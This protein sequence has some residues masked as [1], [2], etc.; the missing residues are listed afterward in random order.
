[1]GKKFYPAIFIL[2]VF[3][4]SVYSRGK[5]DIEEKNV[6]NLDG[7]QES[8]DLTGKSPGKYNIMITATDLGGNQT[9][10][11]PYNIYID[12]KSDLP[13]CGITNP[14]ER[15]R[16]VSNLNIV[17]TCVDDDGVAFVNLILDGDESHP[18]RAEGKEFWSYYLDTRNLAEGPH[19]IK[20]T[21]TDINGLEGKSVSLTWNLDRRQ[22]VTTV[23]NCGM[24]TLVSGS[25]K[26]RGT[27]SDGNG[28]QSLSYS[29]DTGKH[30]TG[31]KITENKKDRN[32]TFDIPVD[33]K[34]TPDGPSVIW[35]KATD[36]AGSVGIYSFLYF[37]D[38]TSP[39]VKI[40]LPEEK[41]PQNGKFYA[42]GY[43]KDKL[44]ITKLT[45]T[46][47][48]DSGEFKLIPGNPYWSHE[49]DTTGLKD[50]S[51]KF[52]VAA[53]DR[54]GN[55]TTVSRTI[56]L[57]QE[58]DK[59]VVTISEPAAGELVDTGK[60]L[61]VRGSAADD[62][63]VQSVTYSIDGVDAGSQ[64]TK[65]V[66]YAPVDGS[67]LKAGKHTVAVTA[68]DRNGVA[69]NPAV[70]SFTAEGPALSFTD[71]VI[72][73]GKDSVPAVNGLDVNPESSSLY[74]TTVS[75]S[76]G[77]T[78][79]EWEFGNESYK[80]AYEVKSAP[81]VLVSIPFKPDMPE[82]VAA[83]T[84]RAT[85]SYNRTA[86]QKVVLHV[87]N[88]TGSAVSQP[89]VVFDDSAV[90]DD[91][92]VLLNR[93]FPLTG[94][95]TGGQIE[96]VKIVPDNPVAEAQFE[97]NTIRILPK[98]TAAGSSGAVVVHVTAKVG[99]QKFGFDSR[100]LV[101]KY[102]AAVPVITV[103]NYSDSLSIDGSPGPVTVSGTVTCTSGVGNVGYRILASRAVLTNGLVTGVK[104]DPVPADQVPVSLDKSG[105]FSFNF[106]AAENGTGM[107]IIEI[108]AESSGGNKCTK[109]VCIRNVPPVPEPAEGRK[110]VFPKA[111]FITWLD[112]SN[113]YYTAVYQGQLD[114][115]FGEFLRTDLQDGMNT[116]SASVQ[117]VDTKVQTASKYAAKKE[118]Q[119]SAYF[120]LINGA[121]YAS[122]TIV[123]L[124]YNDP[125]EPAVL[126][127]SIDSGAA[128]TSA[129]YEITGD[130]AAGGE[131]KQTG[132]A[133]LSKPA[134]GSLRWTAEIPL[135]DLPVRITTIRL[136][137]K[138]GSLTK[139]ISGTVQ[140]VRPQET[141]TGDDERSVLMIP[142]AGVE[143][144]TASSSWPLDTKTPF[145]YYADVPGSIT[146]SLAVPV[147]GLSVAA[148]GKMITLTASKDGFYKNVAV[149]VI[150][151]VSDGQTIT[152]TSK[153]VNFTVDSTGP[154][155]NITEPVLS[156]WV[157]NAVK[158]S[159]TAADQGGINTVEYSTNGGTDWKA[160]D[161]PKKGQGVT[162]TAD[163]P[164]KDLADGLVRI[165]VRA[166]DNTGHET[167]VRTA[168][169]KDTQPPDVQVLL[170]AEQD[171]VN[172]ENLI[173]FVV[174]DTGSIAKAYYVAPPVV[175]KETKDTGKNKG[176]NSGKEPEK[177]E[178][179]K[180]ELEIAPLITTFVGTAD[181]P[182][183]DAMSFEFVDA[184][185]NMTA[186]D[187]WK[188][189]I[190]AESDLPRTEIHLPSD[191]EVLT[192]DFTISGVV[193]DD[194]GPST[195]WYRI[196][197]NAYTK[198]PDAGTSFSIDVPL[199]SLTD[200]EHT[201]S[202]YAVDINGVQ[203]PE[204]VRK[205]RISLEE[206]K[207]A[208]TA[209]AIDTSVRGLI[210]IKGVASDKNGIDK[211][212]VSL[213][214]G[215]S[216]NDATGT[217][218]WVYTVD[219]RAIPDGTQVVFIRI[220]DKYGIQGLYSSLINIDNKSPELYLEL[221]LDDSKT[222]SQL[223][224]SG[225]AFDN[226]GITELYITIRSLEQKN[227][228]KNSAHTDLKPD[229]IVTDVLDISSLENGFYNV[230]MTAKDKAGNI[231]RLSRNI[232]LDK[233]KPLAAVDLLYPLDGE[234]KQGVFTIYGQ[235]VSEKP[236][237]SLHLFIDDKEAGETKLTDSGYFQF[238]I[239]PEMI[240]AG[241]HTYR[242]D[243]Y[244]SG[245]TVIHSR[246]Q[247]VLYSPAG[248]WITVDNFT[249]GDFAHDRP[250]INGSAGYSI[251]ADE[252][253]SSRIKNADPELKKA[254]ALKKVEKVELSLD[255]GKTFVLLS[256]KEKWR[257][258][259]EN[260]DIDAGYHFL[261]VRATMANG[262]TAITRTIVQID[263][264]KPK[265][266]L[267]SPGAGGHY[268]QQLVFSGLTS[269]DV[270]LKDVTLALR[271]G[272]KAAYE[273][274]SFIQGL[275]FD[276]SFW[277][278]TL[279]NIG[280][281]LTFFDDNVKLQVQ[282]G[283]FTQ[284]QRNIF[285]KDDMRY[286]GDSIFGIKILANV[287][288]IPFSYFFGHDFE[289]L[290]ANF[291]IGANFT[292]FSQ[293]NS[294]KAQ[295]LSALLGQIEFPRIT[296]PGLKRFKTF[297]LYTEGS[298][299]FIPTDVS[300]TAT[301]SIQNMVPQISEGIRLNV[302]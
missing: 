63:G 183:N 92:T 57:D 73:T 275:Y 214:N 277:G 181:Q 180:K 66:F 208:V 293:T 234:H 20:A 26:F 45:W 251:D 46:F 189:D 5:K 85:D 254:V 196:D 236:I 182:I 24:G 223:F 41:T 137:V 154:E 104:A 231:T 153:A 175:T 64:E 124:K 68:I 90:G 116:V 226:V 215:N 89:R 288:H 174:K 123:P 134:A 18:V 239:K 51:R 94:Y 218:S 99:D 103:S 224:F 173:A 69:G 3:V 127:A 272:D 139:E 23:T 61:F 4:F 301:T 225:N 163:V 144:D 237:E 278:A 190:D 49:F 140:I 82:G 75:A 145:L 101:F 76:C 188:F 79:I 178:Q 109:A 86:T 65:G 160:F 281:G 230:E 40:V 59:P 264:T 276:W 83:V 1:M 299:W 112:G 58:L 222:T 295:I 269:D 297:S 136:T 122:G 146:A 209:P 244:L 31:V 176:R 128:V 296:M 2:T 159:G 261:L 164:L 256:Q 247:T 290:S 201:V 143:F 249:Y 220:F 187:S 106:N 179:V 72:V 298:L 186:I 118:I 138:A 108:T 271:K 80:N 39:D 260:Q 241:T 6:K 192:R 110:A 52:T 30:F 131:V 229:R 157:K 16:V 53:T 268:N 19:T 148:D 88:M 98:D 111:P 246:T 60:N 9:V 274:P 286:G 150:E 285:E 149:K 217:E 74:Q 28:I 167:I 105:S 216:Y 43:A 219:T 33:T 100:K 243:S 121:P 36:K 238:D 71:P 91:G 282:W 289:W 257:Y 54:A 141:F 258:R 161:I 96:S 115:D 97:N 166:R 213:D 273:I 265:V 32:W 177:T 119:L 21:G 221:P 70:V 287:G 228:S 200:N 233:T 107:F 29:L 130:A 240:A 15:M 259:I 7:W 212:Q 280:A 10:E 84:V 170:P 248:P 263:N 205:F 193:Y 300:G 113:V 168:V 62:D 147:D 93:E 87:M 207:G 22:P 95:F 250:Y 169:Q 156:A 255:N 199:A 185:G 132:N 194:D 279:Y 81:S 283:Q 42:A 184:C 102:D 37:I 11:G 155:V 284:A 202:V 191:N 8:F 13:V 262:E 126:S 133:K 203:G 67:A 206:P 253:L 77:I 35:F 34:K 245:S 204:T 142:P 267:I 114:R 47:G 14:H 227:V 135:A 294:G 171:V 129:V 211:V 25:C 78:H 292:R 44:G 252:L 158:I 117:A 55:I 197:A 17:G 27:I 195:I 12:P 242:V 162:F 232:E 291:A 235:V 266:R 56:P 38:N 165:D 198:L 120:A 270:K 50:K 210:Q 172:G 48:P 302:F 152:Y 125:K 151:N